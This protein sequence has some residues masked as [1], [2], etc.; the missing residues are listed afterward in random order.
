ML[1]NLILEFNKIGGSIL[2]ENVGQFWM[3]FDNFT[4]EDIPFLVNIEFD[5]EVKRYIRIP[6]KTK[7][8]WIEETQLSPLLRGWA[9]EAISE[10]ELAGR[11]NLHRANNQ[12]KGIAELQIVIAKK[13]WGRRFGREVADIMLKA[14]F[15]ELNA[16]AVIAEVHPENHSSIALLQDFGFCYESKSHKEPMQLYKLIRKEIDA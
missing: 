1:Q 11:V 15:N 7:E 6:T 10:G 4:I 8:K 13:F 9:I 14:A 3:L 2:I 5:S 16:I 12:P